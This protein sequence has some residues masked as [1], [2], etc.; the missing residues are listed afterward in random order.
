MTSDMAG[1][2]VGFAV[3]LGVFVSILG[4]VELGRRV[5]LRRRAQ[6]DG[7]STV[8]L[9]AIDTAIFG[10]MGLLL[11]FA[12]AG[13]LTRWEF[14]R[15]T[16]VNETNA[17]GSA[18]IAVDLLPADAQPAVREQ[19]RDYVD[20][21]IAAFVDVLDEPVVAASL[22]K[23]AGA[24]AEMWRL[25]VAA[26]PKAPV[27]YAATMFLSALSD[28]FNSATE[29][30]AAPLT[31]PPEVMYALLFVLV[32]ASGFIAGTGTAATAARP[33]IRILVLASVLA[34]TMYVLID[35]EYPR[36]GFIR[37]DFADQMIVDLR[38]SMG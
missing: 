13:A 28:M 3:P 8:G 30:N 9:T 10:L 23:S 35:I 6:A 25:S 20:A 4:T 26:T 17:I 7:D 15:Q 14:R 22:R 37:I 24:Q 18:W 33:W 38:K 11:G 27:P 29:R 16:I 1:I 19:F 32:L 12:F 5:G 36:A 34:A 21:R 31:H 2:L